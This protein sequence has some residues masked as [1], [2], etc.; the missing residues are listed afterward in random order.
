M[1][2]K[3]KGRVPFVKEL[4]VVKISAKNLRGFRREI[5]CMEIPRKE[6]VSVIF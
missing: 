4:A 2:K 5:P 3:D 6:P 1:L